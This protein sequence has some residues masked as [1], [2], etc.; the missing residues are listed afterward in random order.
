MRWIHWST[1]WHGGHNIDHHV[2]VEVSSFSPSVWY[3]VLLLE[4]ANM[5]K[6]VLI[7]QR[8]VL[9]V[10]VKKLVHHSISVPPTLMTIRKELGLTILEESSLN[11]MTE[12]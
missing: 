6:V 4:A 3:K 1:T 11:M 8:V 5:V 10:L 7:S 9:N 2:R 12:R